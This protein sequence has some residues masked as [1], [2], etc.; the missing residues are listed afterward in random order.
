MTRRMLLASLVLVLAARRL[1]RLVEVELPD[2]RRRAHLCARGSSSRRL[3]SRSASRRQVSFTITQPNGKPLTA[4]QA[5]PRP[6]HRRA[7][8]HRAPR[9]RIDRPPCIHRSPRTG[10]SARRHVHEAGPVSRRRRRVPEHD[11]AAARTSSC[12]ARCG[13]QAGT[14][15]RRRRRSASTVA[16][17]GYRVTHARTARRCMP[18]RRVPDDHRHRPEREARASSHRGSARSRTRSSSVR[19]RSTTSTRTSVRPGA[20]GCT[21]FLGGDQ[22]DGKL[23]DAREAERRRAR[24]RRRDVAP[25]PADQGE[26]SR[27][28]RAVHARRQTMTKEPLP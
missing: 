13:S 10:R 3:R 19:E 9:P 27:P 4:V 2:D 5:R 12:S 21:S 14:S 8:D 28:D 23:D 25:L 17:D 24:A 6:A 22:G 1:R 7:S 26:R 20:S 18:S 11:G 15:R 16:V